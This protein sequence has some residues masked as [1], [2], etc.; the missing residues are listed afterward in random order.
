MPQ[1]IISDRGGPFLS[2]L[3]YT[4]NKIFDIEHRHSSGWRPQT[5]GK[6]EKFNETLISMLRAYSVKNSR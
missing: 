1:V 6:T 3:V 4:V 5:N 2:D